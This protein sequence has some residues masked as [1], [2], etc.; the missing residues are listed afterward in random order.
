MIPSHL[1]ELWRL[2]K[3]FA[4]EYYDV[5]SYDRICLETFREDLYNDW[6]CNKIFEES[7]CTPEN[8]IEADQIIKDRF[9]EMIRKA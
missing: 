4:N 2:T 3:D 6:R 5:E 7:E 8:M 9:V 1:L